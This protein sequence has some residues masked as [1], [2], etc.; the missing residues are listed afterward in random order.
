QV[1]WLSPGGC[2][3]LCLGGP[4]RLF[5]DGRHSRF[6]WPGSSVALPNWLVTT[7]SGVGCLGAAILKHSKCALGL[8]T[9]K[10]WPVGRVLTTGLQWM[11]AAGLTLALKPF[12]LNWSFSTMLGGILYLPVTV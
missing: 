8:V 3:A 5:Q 1:K 4:V 9:P 7:T 11:T 12:G 10:T 2:G 6:G